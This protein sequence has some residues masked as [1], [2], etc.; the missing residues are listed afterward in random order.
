MCRVT[1]SNNYLY[2]KPQIIFFVELLGIISLNHEPQVESL[3][4]FV[5]VY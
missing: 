3:I 4:Y 2:E 1:D 5:L